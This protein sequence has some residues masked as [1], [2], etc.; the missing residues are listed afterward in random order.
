M[1]TWSCVESIYSPLKQKASEL[2]VQMF[3]KHF[4]NI[5]LHFIYGKHSYPTETKYYHF[6][7]SQYNLWK[8][9]SFLKSYLSVA[10]AV[11][12]YYQTK[13]EQWAKL[14]ILSCSAVTVASG[15]SVYCAT[16]TL[17]KM[18]LEL[19]HIW[20]CDP[21]SIWILCS[22]L[23]SVPQQVMGST[24]SRIQG[25]KMATISRSSPYTALKQP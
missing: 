19:W 15:L 11:S 22:V 21:V 17:G 3:D 8:S 14:A 4:L 20:I 25:E 1:T 23:L 12:H 9:C 24:T 5:Y 7:G 13:M 18:T 16:K 10:F 2:T 6:I